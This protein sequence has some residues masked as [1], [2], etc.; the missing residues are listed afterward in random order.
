VDGHKAVVGHSPTEGY[1]IAVKASSTCSRLSS[2][3]TEQRHEQRIRAC[4][5]RFA[6]CIDREKAWPHQANRSGS[7][8]EPIVLARE[9]LQLIAEEIGERFEDFGALH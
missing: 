3:G 1:Y 9:L 5:Y 8:C 4:A 6:L 7:G 2:Q